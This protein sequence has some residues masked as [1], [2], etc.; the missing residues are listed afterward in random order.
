MNQ[1]KVRRR[2]LAAAGALVLGHLLFTT[3]LTWGTGGALAAVRAPGPAGVDS[4]LA[5]V[6]AAGAWAVLTWLTAG[7]LLALLTAAV[8]GLGSRAHAR[9]VS[10]TPACTRRLVAAVLGLAVAASPLAGGRPAS[11]ADRSVAA[12]ALPSVDHRP[13]HLDALDE[14]DELD[15]PVVASPAG[16]TPDRPVVRPRQAG[17]SARAVRL[18]TTPARAGLAP[19][20]EVVVHRGDSLWDIAARHLGADAGAAEIAAEWPRWYLA[21]R[22]VIGE[23]PD[24]L[25]PGQLLSPPT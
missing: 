10:L 13:D 2:G 19:R 23:D 4:A 22:S 3:A 24:L 11:A 5:L 8:T 25:R 9:A 21:N 12:A 15:R 18:V 20:S 16:W 14:P 7:A 6:A 1:V 17:S